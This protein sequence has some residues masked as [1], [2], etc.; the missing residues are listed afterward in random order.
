MQIGGEQERTDASRDEMEALD[1]ISND[2][3]RESPDNNG[4][5]SDIL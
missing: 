1:T 3:A 4:V 5:F 2:S